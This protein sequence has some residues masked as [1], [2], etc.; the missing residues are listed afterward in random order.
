MAKA[1]KKREDKYEEK[2]KIEGTFEDVIGVS[3]DVPPV[4]KED[5][6]KAK[7]AFEEGTGGVGEKSIDKKKPETK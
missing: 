7:N 5:A 6:D 1:K 3:M 2:L 4:K